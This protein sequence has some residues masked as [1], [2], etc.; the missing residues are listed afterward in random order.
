M[1]LKM[2]VLGITIAMCLDWL[3]RAVV[4]WMRYRRGKWK[5]E[6]IS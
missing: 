2:D 3:T 5:S 6:V 1:I 4:F